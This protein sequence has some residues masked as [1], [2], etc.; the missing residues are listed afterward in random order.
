MGR[1]GA[2]K[3]AVTYCREHDILREFLEKHGT[4]VMNMLITEWNWDEALAVRYNEGW[5][6]GLEKGREE[7]LE[8]GREEIA[9]NAL[10][11]GMSPEAVSEI[12]G[13]D[14]ETIKKLG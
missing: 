14:V 3:R 9:R 11:K 12:T 10:A 7:G 6:G 1:E 5:E 2:L 4:E 8:E 13:L